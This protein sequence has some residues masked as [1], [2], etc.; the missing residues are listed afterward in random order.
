MRK[1]ASIQKIEKITPIPNADRVEC[2]HIL[3]WEVVVGKNS[4]K[5]NDLCVF[6][7]IDSLLPEWECFEFL[8]KS[9]WMEKE[10]R[11]RIRTC[12]LA[13]QV[14]QGFAI[15]IDDTV[16]S[17][18]K[19]DSTVELAI[20][21]DVTTAFDVKKYVPE[22]PAEMLEC[23]TEFS[24]PISITEEARI[25][26]QPTLLQKLLGMEYYIAS[27]LNGESASILLKP[28]DEIIGFHV[29][30]H[31]Y[32]YKNTPQT[33]SFWQI[34]DKYKAKNKL[35]EFFERTGV[36]LGLQGEL[37]GPGIRKNHLGLDELDLYIFNVWDVSNRRRFG[38]D[39]A[40]D[41]VENIGM[42]FVP[43]IERKHCFDHTQSSLLALAN[44]NYI[45][46]GFSK[47][48]KNK[49]EGI[50]VRSID[51]KNSFK[52]ISNSFLLDN[53]DE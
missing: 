37:V 23:A 49:R 1:L 22:I 13:K 41:I 2:A 42:K 12:V 19:V 3:G 28:E 25:Q 40:M 21:D 38:L 32:S 39:D 24:W 46:D 30:G 17:I 31:N 53:K 18:L 45:E 44:G 20:D 15:P 36:M 43:V 27:K 34:E 51:M 10:K 26:S 6:F 4:F 9:T 50:V 33:K 16:L 8:R 47:A 29:C 35:N 14:S 5:E 11:F 7:E 52:V 48:G